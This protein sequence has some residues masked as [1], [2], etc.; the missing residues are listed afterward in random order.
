[1]QNRSSATGAKFPTTQWEDLL[2]LHQDGN[3]QVRDRVV[4][5]LCRDYWFPLYAFARL[6]GLRQHDAEDAVQSFFLLTGDAGFFEKADQEKGKF[7]TFLLTAFT[8][9]LGRRNIHANALKRGGGQIHM[10]IDSAQAEI[11]LVAD[12]QSTGEDAA[13]AFERHWAK[14][15]IRSAIAALESEASATSKSAR[16]FNIISRF[17]TPEGCL[18]Y[19]IR[20]AA[21]ELEIT[22]ASCEKSIQRL[23]AQFRHAVRQQVAQTLR[24]PTEE[25][26]TEEMLQLQRSLMG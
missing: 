12:P 8:R 23:R 15:I 11:W 22:V 18:D 2:S 19:T 4:R 6:R 20:Q 25:S 3:T 13:L 10:P 14:S 24:D 1:M 21:E 9:Q 17:L 7:R 26:V 16:R 5:Q